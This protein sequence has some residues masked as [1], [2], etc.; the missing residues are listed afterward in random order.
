MAMGTIVIEVDN[1]QTANDLKKVMD[2]VSPASLA[3]F[4]ETHGEA[5]ILRRL[6]AR[7]AS[8]GD[9]A[10]GKWLPLTPLTQDFR[11][12]DGFAPEHPINQRTG[13]LKNWLESNQGMITL[14]GVG[15]GAEMVFPGDQTAPDFWTGVKFETAQIGKDDPLTPP[16]PIIVINQED[17]VLVYNALAQ[18]LMQR[19]SL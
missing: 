9:S 5:I 10:S 17:H 4:L 19:M 16:R 2:S 3:L 11:R 13:T 14:T 7:F 1:V 12:W 18:Y 15:A 8:E 6:A